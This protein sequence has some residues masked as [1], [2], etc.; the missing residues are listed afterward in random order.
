MSGW[1][2]SECTSLLVCNSG[3]VVHET[4]DCRAID[5]G[6]LVWDVREGIDCAPGR[7]RRVRN[8]CGGTGYRYRFSHGYR[9]CG[10]QHSQHW[11]LRLTGVSP[12]MDRLSFRPH[13]A[14]VGPKA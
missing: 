8:V 4:H 2:S 6:Y 12:W 13:Q 5:I 7:R 10:S 1:E 11:Y 3:V 9:R 14:T